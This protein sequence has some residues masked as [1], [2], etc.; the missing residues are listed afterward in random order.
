[1]VG[2]ALMVGVV[3]ALPA[4]AKLLDGCPLIVGGG[5]APEASWLGAALLEGCPLIVGCGVP[6][7][8]SDGAALS[9]GAGVVP[10]FVVGVVGATL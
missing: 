9:V 4:G 6:P 1:M 2:D 5:V 8:I 10:L 7:L 3:V